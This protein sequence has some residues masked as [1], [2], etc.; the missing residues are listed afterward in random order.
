MAVSD[1]LLASERSNAAREPVLAWC[2]EQGL[3]AYDRRTQAGLLRNLVVREGRRTGQLQV[4]LVTGPGD[5]DGPSLAAAVECDGL[6]WTPTDAL[7]ETT[8][9]GETISSPATARSRRSSAA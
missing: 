7:A 4:R 8:L 3:R 9:G 2:R 6:S 5:F 1:C